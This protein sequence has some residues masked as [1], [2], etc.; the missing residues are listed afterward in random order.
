MILSRR[1]GD[2]SADTF[3]KEDLNDLCD[4]LAAKD[5]RIKQIL[6]E[7]GYPP[8]WHR[9]PEFQSLVMIILEQQVSLA[10]AFSTFQKLKEK[11]VDITPENIQKMSDDDF[12]TCGFSRQKK[13]YVEGLA[14]EVANDR[15]N[16]EQLKS[17]DAGTIRKKLLKIKGIGNWT[18]DIYLLSCLHKLDI[19]PIGDLALIKSMVQAK[20]I[21]E[22]DSKEDILRKTEKLKPYRSIFTIIM[23]HRYI[24]S[25][26]IQVQFDL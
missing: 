23:W 24:K 21:K 13:T 5:K 3:G 9:N 6:I 2:N 15:L 18:V 20:I 7:F 8:F 17:E 1:I 10:S 22:T 19:F 12:K 26:N 25:N 11:L 16:L 14:D 4:L